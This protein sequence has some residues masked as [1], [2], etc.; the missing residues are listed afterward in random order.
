MPPVDENT[1]QTAQNSTQNT[2]SA[3]S[4]VD[5]SDSPGENLAVSNSATP[6]SIPTDTE[7]DIKKLQDSIANL[8]FYGGKL[9]EDEIH[10]LENKL[11]LLQEKAKQEAAALQAGIQEAEQKTEQK[12]Q[13]LADQFYEKTGMRPWGLAILIG[14]F[15]AYKLVATFI[16]WLK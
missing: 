14:L 15:V 1:N 12:V 11:V 13:T 10:S 2:T 9:A 6:D 4:A 8:K 16:P 3:S 5:A 7:Q